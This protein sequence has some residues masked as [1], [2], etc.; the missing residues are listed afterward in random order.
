MEPIT[1]TIL[2][3]HD[4]TQACLLTRPWTVLRE[5]Q[6]IPGHGD[7]HFVGFKYVGYPNEPSQTCN[8]LIRDM[9][10]E[11]TRNQAIHHNL[12]RTVLRVDDR[13][14][15]TRVEMFIMPPLSSWTRFTNWWYN[16]E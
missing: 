13:D 11:V 2:R 7:G 5:T 12:P 9:E 8:E 15:Y 1:T 4:A 10:Y 14:E 16:T 6:A 3:S